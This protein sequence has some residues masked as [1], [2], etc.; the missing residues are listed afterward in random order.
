MSAFLLGVVV[1][2]AGALAWLLPPLLRQRS[3]AKVTQDAVNAA[4]YRDQLREL[5]ADLR[6]GVIAAEQH[7]VARQ[8]LERRVLEDLGTKG[9]TQSPQRSRRAWIGA[10]ALGL[11]IPVCAF[12]VYFAVG[13]PQAVVPGA[14][15]QAAAD[16]AG[17]VTP[18][19]VI[20]M[21]DRLAAKLK[22]NPDNPEGWAMLGKSYGVMGRYDEA[23]RAFAEAAK[24]TPDDAQLLADYADALAM[25]QG[26]RLQGEP[27]KLIARALKADPDNVKAL[28]LAGTAAFERK[29]YSGALRHWERILRT[30]PPGSPLAQS[31]QASIDEAR[32]LGGKGSAKEI[33]KASASPEASSSTQSVRGIARL[34]PQMAAKVAPTDTVFIYARAAQGSRM[35]LAILRKQARDL[36]VSFVLDDSMAM[37]AQAKLSSAPSIIVTARVSKGAQATAQPGD[38]EGSS[39]PVKAG[40]GG[41]EVL[42]DSEVR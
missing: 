27:E 37:S 21:V 14:V 36:P 29:D 13:T 20:A 2:V 30:A 41:V 35:P 22:E 12:L 34:A 15:E 40:A 28:A 10:V 19:Q 31:V 32:S 6:A 3:T 7:A 9:A 39:K 18:D 17:G 8:E 26:Q 25:S 16:A 23:T 38:I 4:V 1:L 33:A 5:D 42:I 24:R 11:A